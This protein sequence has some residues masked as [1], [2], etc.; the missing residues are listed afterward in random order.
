ME[1]KG[2]NI[3]DCVNV[4]EVLGTEY[5]SFDDRFS[6][7]VSLYDVLA[8]LQVLSIKAIGESTKNCFIRLKRFK[9]GK[10]VK[11]RL[12]LLKC[13]EENEEER[14]KRIEMEKRK[15][16]AA[17]NGRRIVLKSEIERA[18]RLLSENGYVVTKN[19]N[20]ECL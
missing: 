8:K 7:G 19:V 3:E 13:R 17:E 2:K 4:F 16:D 15:I 11:Y 14:N 1:Y 20:S 6:H 5:L 9:C 12:R 10:E 18:K